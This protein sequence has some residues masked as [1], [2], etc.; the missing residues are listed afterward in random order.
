MPET[1]TPF[2]W[3]MQPA[4]ATAAGAATL[5][6]DNLRFLNLVR[7]RFQSVWVEDHFLDVG[8]DR[9]SVV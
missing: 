4:P 5:N 6:E 8:R 7:S 2:G 9:K 3:V 1:H